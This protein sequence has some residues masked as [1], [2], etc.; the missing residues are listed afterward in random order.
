MTDTYS[1]GPICQDD[2]QA[3]M[4]IF[5]Y[6]IEHTWAAYPEDRVPELFFGLI[7]EQCRNYPTV[8]A[9][10][11][12]GLLAG[13]GLLHPFH[14]MPAF[15]RTV[16][17]SYFVRP[18]LTGKGIGSGML[19]YLEAEAKQK[20]IA[21]ILA[22]ISSLNEESLRFHE[23]RGFFECGRIRDAGKKRGVLFDMVWMQ[24]QL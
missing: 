18:G 6:Y 14:P 16:E 24:K 23:R 4:E 8:A 17:V 12:P 7:M 21:N 15:F 13:F 9:R 22:N 5:N 11:E 10:Q 1:F 20:G 19:S 3:I 2:Q